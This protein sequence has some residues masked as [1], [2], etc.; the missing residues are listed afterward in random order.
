[1][2]IFSVRSNSTVSQ[3]YNNLSRVQS[4]L[5][6]NIGRLSSGLR[7]N[8]AS[9]DSAGSSVAVRMVSQINGMK[10]A[11]ANAQQANNLL[12]TAESGLSDI[13]DILGRMRELAV[14][15]STDTLNNDDRGSIDLEFQALQSEISRI[16]SATEYDDNALLDGSYNNKSLQIGADNDSN[17]QLSISI[18]DATS[19]EGL[20]LGKTYLTSNVATDAV[21]ATVGDAS[22]LAAGDTIVIGGEQMTISAA[23]V[24]NVLTVT[25]A[26][27]SA[28]RAV[29]TAND[30]V[31]GGDGADVKSVASARSAI[32]DLDG[33]IDRVNDERSRV[34][35]VQNRLSFTISNLSNHTQAI[36]AGRSAI[37]DV[38]FAAEATELAKNQILAQ[39]GAAMLA[40][41]TVVSQN[42]LGLL[43]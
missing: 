22:G 17:H 20:G 8:S 19:A 34:G 21:K 3:A 12:Q 23:D 2:S 40:Q 36:E 39:S 35:A 16:A 13:S 28:D 7:I 9:D 29:H 14:Q 25:R 24:N 43:I 30:E 27:P 6:A 33:A 42:V 37:A 38:D 41:A 26:T 1:M 10:Q 11:N 5:N 31:F 15:A 18:G 32:T 4:S